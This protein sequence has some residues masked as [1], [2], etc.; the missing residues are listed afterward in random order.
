[1]N[2]AAPEF[3]LDPDAR[4]IR[5][6]GEDVQLAP[7]EFELLAL[8]LAQPGQVLT[9]PQI[10]QAIWGRS[11]ES[12]TISVHVSWL[13]EKLQRFEPL[14]FRITTVFRVGYRLDRVGYGRP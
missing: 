9:R 13:R 5:L 3:L 6:R 1:M 12:N 7:K 2:T 11:L 8:L 14:P 4:T 10:S